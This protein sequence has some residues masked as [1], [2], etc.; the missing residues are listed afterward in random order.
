L[1]KQ[2]QMDRNMS[3]MMNFHEEKEEDLELAETA[4]N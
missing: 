1:I 3:S 4:K 2:N